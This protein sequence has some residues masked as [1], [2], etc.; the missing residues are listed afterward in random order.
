MSFV[1]LPSS[2]IDFPE[3]VVTGI[4]QSTKATSLVVLPISIIYRTGFLPNMCTFPLTTNTNK[5]LYTLFINESRTICRYFKIRALH[6]LLYQP[7][8]PT[9]LFYSVYIH[10]TILF[11]RGGGSRCLIAFKQIA[12]IDPDKISEEIFP[13]F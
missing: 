13:S 5:T 12:L 3:H 8:S 6:S 2:R 9:L 4:T 10:Q 7:L 1:V 11:I